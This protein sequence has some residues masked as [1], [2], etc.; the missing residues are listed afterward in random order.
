[1][2][3]V[4]APVH[5]A[6]HKPLVFFAVFTAQATLSGVKSGACS[7][8]ICCLDGELTPRAAP[9]DRCQ[10]DRPVWQELAARCDRSP[11]CLHDR[12]RRA[13][14]EIAELQAANAG[15]RRQLA[16]AL[17]CPEG[18]YCVLV[19]PGPADDVTGPA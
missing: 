17:G 11:L 18:A 8:F 2:G 13:Q 19:M 7:S 12:L 1:M 5:S 15:L 10:Q 16:V 4:P 3:V 6:V 14:D 9:A